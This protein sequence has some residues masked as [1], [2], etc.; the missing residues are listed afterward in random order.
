[1]KGQR[2]SASRIAN[3]WVPFVVAA[4]VA[5][6]QGGRMALVLPAELHKVNY[7]AQLCSFLSNSSKL[8]DIIP[9]N[10]LFYECVEQ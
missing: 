10:K 5:L 3:I 7:A 1:M 6:R 4:A 8:I 2:F 9:C